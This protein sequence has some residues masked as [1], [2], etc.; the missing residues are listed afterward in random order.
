MDEM[1]ATERLA[2]FALGLSLERV[3]ESVRA[4]ARAAII[5]GLAC[6]IAGRDERVTRALRGFAL[7]QGSHP[8]ATPG[9]RA[10]ASRPCRSSRACRTRARRRFRTRGEAPPRRA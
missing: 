6:A 1:S 7:E 10:T 2:G 4:S 9:P 5:D 3:P 8:R